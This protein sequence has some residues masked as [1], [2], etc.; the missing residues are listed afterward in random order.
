[1]SQVK[2]V[3]CKIF[4]ICFVL[5]SCT[6]DKAELSDDVLV[7]IVMDAQTLE[8]ASNH[9]SGS[10]RDSITP[11]YYR[12]LFKKYNLE[13]A[14]FEKLMDELGKNPIRAKK[15]YGIVSDSLLSK[16]KKPN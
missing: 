11:C 2:S 5:Q 15:I 14:E 9:L 16:Q 12:A 7:K 10:M 8:A 13:K 1:M 6:T 4:F 3:I